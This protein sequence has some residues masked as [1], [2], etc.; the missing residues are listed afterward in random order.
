MPV[1]EYASFSRWVIRGAPSTHWG[2]GR[3]G[4]GFLGYSDDE[5]VTEEEVTDSDSS[6]FW[7]NG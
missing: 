4:D 1:D 5:E 7:F 3:L 2:Y 6:S